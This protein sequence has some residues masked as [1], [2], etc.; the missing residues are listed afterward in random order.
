AAAA[1][2]PAAPVAPPPDPEAEAL[3]ALVAKLDGLE[4]KARIA[5]LESWVAANAENRFAA[6]VRD[7]ARVLRGLLRSRARRAPEEAAAA[8]APAATGTIELL[9]FSKPD[10]VVTGAPL[11]IAVEVGGDV[12]GVVLH[13]RDT[14]DVSF[15]SEPM[16]PAGPR[17]WTVTLPA[18]RVREPSLEVAVEAIGPDDSSVWIVATPGAPLRLRAVDPPTP[19]PP[20]RH[21]STATVWTDYADYNRL[22]GDD[23][24]FITEGVFGMRLADVGVRSVR[25]GFG[26]Y[27]G[28]GGSVEELDDLGLRPREVGLTYGHLE[29]EV[30]FSR[31]L[32]GVA[33]A[34]AGLRADGL[35]GGGQLQLRIGSDLETNLLVGGEVLGGIGLRGAAALE[36]APRSRVPIVVRTEV[37]N[38]PAGVE[39]AGGPLSGRA[40]LASDVGGRAG[41]Q[42][43]YRIVPSFVVFGRLSYQGRTIV[44]AGPGFGGGASLEW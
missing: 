21:G 30:G 5:T 25:T 33:R 10:R 18:S 22:R 12:R 35:G 43:G 19:A 27:R 16:T 31:T 24:V 32:S 26:V 37:T 6:P 40:R 28:V 11:A 1:Q 36:L 34:T 8:P 4:A 38:Q 7:E 42:V 9:G 39:A 44:H 14:A 15:V 29:A 3:G 41:V 20:L 17:Y 13:S 23:R 2:A